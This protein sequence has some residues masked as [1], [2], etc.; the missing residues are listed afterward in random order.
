MGA[1]LYRESLQNQEEVPS[2]KTPKTRIDK[3]KLQTHPIV[4]EN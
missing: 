3:W 1:Q 2:T 4:M